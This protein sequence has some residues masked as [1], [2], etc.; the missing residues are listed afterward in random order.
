M[1]YTTNVLNSELIKK[2]SNIYSL[3]KVLKDD[4][5]TISDYIKGNRGDRLY[6]K[7]W[8]IIVREQ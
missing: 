8:K 2:Y 3:A 7:Q 1:I 6:R 5:A 4:Y